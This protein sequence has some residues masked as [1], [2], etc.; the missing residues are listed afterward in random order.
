MTRRYILAI[1]LLLGCGPKTVSLGEAHHIE[2]LVAAEPANPTAVSLMLRDR[3]S[4]L[5]LSDS[6]HAAFDDQPMALKA[7]GGTTELPDYSIVCSNALFGTWLPNASDSGSA[8][9][10]TIEDDRHEIT[11]ELPHYLLQPT[12]TLS[13][14]TWHPGDQVTASW[15]PSD[16][17]LCGA[18][19]GQCQAFLAQSPSF[20]FSYDSDISARLEGNTFTFTVPTTVDVDAGT[21]QFV[22]WDEGTNLGPFA[23]DPFPS[24]LPSTPIERCEGA[25]SCIATPPYY[26]API[27]IVLEP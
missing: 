25:E 23:I 20:Q 4:C 24:E 7:R 22:V 13:S 21:G 1:L 15:S 6:A 11:I 16:L 12:M 5:E 2:V 26:P 19:G 10:F 3:E 27:D 14:T 9:V 18:R 17:E 8:H